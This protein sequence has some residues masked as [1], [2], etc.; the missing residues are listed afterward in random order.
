[1]Y[2]SY[3]VGYEQLDMKGSDGLVIG[4]NNLEQLKANLGQLVESSMQE[5]VVRV[6]G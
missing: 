2:V 1:M 3:S 4:V 6:F 5:E